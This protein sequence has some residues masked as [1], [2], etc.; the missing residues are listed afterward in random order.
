MKLHLDN[1]K[2]EAHGLC[3][4]RAP[5]LFD[6]DNDGYAVLLDDS[7]TGEMVDLA[8]IAER[9]CPEGAISITED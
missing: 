6:C 5:Q 9:A 7:P 1:S 2:C 3:Y 8:Q 4:G